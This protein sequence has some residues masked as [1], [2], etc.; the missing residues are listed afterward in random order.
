MS[1]SEPPT[2][3][4]LAALWQRHRSGPRLCGRVGAVS[5]WCAA[6]QLAVSTAEQWRLPELRRSWVQGCRRQ[7][8]A[9]WECMWCSTACTCAVPPGWLL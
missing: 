8:H 3:Q 5:S 7:A 6:A 9:Y 4:Q 2:G 1:S